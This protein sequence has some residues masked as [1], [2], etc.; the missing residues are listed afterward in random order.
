MW[1]VYIYFQAKLQATTYGSFNFKNFK[2]KFQT[3]TE[4]KFEAKAS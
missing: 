2:V 1:E 3:M 4:V